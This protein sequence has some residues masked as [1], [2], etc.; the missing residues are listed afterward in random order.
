VFPHSSRPGSGRTRRASRVSLSL[1]F[2]SML[3]SLTIPVL[4][5]TTA[6]AA[7][8]TPAAGCPAV[9][10][11]QPFLKWGDTSSYELVAGGS[12]EGSLAGWTLGSGVQKVAGSESYGVTGAVGSSSLALP[13]GATVQSPFT[14]VD[15]RFRTFRFFA[16]ATG[17]TS[18]V[19]VHVTYQTPIG[20]VSVPVGTVTATNGWQPT[21]VM[22]TGA[23]V[24]GALL[25]GTAQMALTFTSVTG[26]SVIDDVFVDPRMR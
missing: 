1:C 26:S 24:A 4:T 10:L 9:A 7:T 20:L 19:L 6:Q 12:F 15:S 14:C 18:K 21:Q 8:V 17:A 16:R 13:S 2:A 25:G 22:P 11:T 3:A 5:A 23:Q